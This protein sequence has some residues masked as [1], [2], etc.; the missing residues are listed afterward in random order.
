LFPHFGV[1]PKCRIKNEQPSFFLECGDGP[2]PW[3]PDL[4]DI[5]FIV[6]VSISMLCHNP[7]D[8]CLEYEQLKFYMKEFVSAHG[9]EKITASLIQFAE[10][11]NVNIKCLL[12]FIFFTNTVLSVEIY[13]CL[14]IF[15]FLCTICGGG[16]GK[17]LRKLVQ[18]GYAFKTAYFKPYVFYKH[19][20]VVEN[21]KIS[22]N[23]TISMRLL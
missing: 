18:Q 23:K 16:S 17:V 7:E 3:C 20:L 9:F 15:L 11:T 22:K 2:L 13:F 10:T 21:K 19:L 14:K 4:M 1:I 8:E 12:Y 6:D 5:V